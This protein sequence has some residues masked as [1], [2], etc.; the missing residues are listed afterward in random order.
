MLAAKI[1]DLHGRGTSVCRM[2]KTKQKER[3]LNA[4]VE[5]LIKDERKIFEADSKPKM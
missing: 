2:A 5:S 1:T 3:P 4:H